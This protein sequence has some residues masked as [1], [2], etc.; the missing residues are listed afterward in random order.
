MA[1]RVMNTGRKFLYV[2]FWHLADIPTHLIN[3]RFWGQSG[4]CRKARECLLMIQSGHPPSIHINACKL[5]ETS[6]KSMLRPDL[7]QDQTSASGTDTRSHDDR[8]TTY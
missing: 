3:V 5:F 7:S 4:H 1:L 8:P 6:M 2:R